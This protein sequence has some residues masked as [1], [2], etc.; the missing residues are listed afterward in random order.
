[1]SPA[2]LNVLISILVLGV[3]GVA[4]STLG[5]F[6]STFVYLIGHMAFLGIRKP[7]VL[8]PVAA[9]TLLVFY[10]VMELLLG[11]GLPRGVLI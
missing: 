4:I 7:Q 11:V 10:L 8:V 9:G 2:H 3:Y 6:V 5:F 1:M